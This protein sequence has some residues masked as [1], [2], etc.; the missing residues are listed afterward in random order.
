MTHFI[1]KIIVHDHLSI[2]AFTLEFVFKEIF[3]TNEEEFY[4]DHYDFHENR[5]YTQYDYKMD[6]LRQSWISFI[7]ASCAS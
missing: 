4:F 2:N 6:E 5:I 3:F 7:S 1:K